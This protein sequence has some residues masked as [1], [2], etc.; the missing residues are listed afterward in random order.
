MIH[1]PFQTA[2]DHDEFCRS[3]QWETH[4]YALAQTLVVPTNGGKQKYSIL[5]SD[6]TS[7]SI[8]HSHSSVAA[9]TAIP[10][11]PRT[12][13]KAYHYCQSQMPKLD[14]YI[15][16]TLGQRGG[17]QGRIR[18]WSVE[19]VDRAYFLTYQMCDNRWCERIGRPHKSNNIMWT[20]DLKNKVA[21]QSCHD[22]DCRGFRGDVLK[23]DN[24]P[25]EASDEIDEFLFDRELEQLD[26]SILVQNNNVACDNEFSND[27]MDKELRD[28]DLPSVVSPFAKT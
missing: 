14:K 21:W 13:P 24:L 3:L 8:T 28:L 27:D 25:Q 4:A 7:D 10:D 16:S 12:K 17:T 23:L 6:V 1:V 15:L 19:S 26:E 22:S 9:L 20:V 18:A 5:K 2:H 11:Q